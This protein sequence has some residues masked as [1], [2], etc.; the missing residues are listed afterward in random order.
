MGPA[1]P[2]M[3]TM[4]GVTF[5]GPITETP[6]TGT[7]E[8]WVII[9][10]TADTHPIHTH[11]ASFQLVSRQ[12]FQAAKYFKDWMTL[13]AEG[14]QMLPFQTPTSQRQLPPTAYLQQKPTAALPT[15]MGWKDTVQM[16]PGEVTIIRIRWTQQDGTAYPFDPTQGPGYVWHCHIVDHEDNEMM[17]PYT[18]QP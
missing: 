3:V 4:N 10:L 1:G 17:R 14:P 12:P 6:K 5:R 11:L 15:E 2:Q 8:D 18:V 13:N 16:N 9:N 7:T